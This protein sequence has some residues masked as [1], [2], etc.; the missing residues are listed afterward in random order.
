MDYRLQRIIAKT[1]PLYHIILSIDTMLQFLVNML[2][3][4]L[5]FVGNQFTSAQP[6]S[7]ATNRKEAREWSYIELDW[8]YQ[9]QTG[10]K[11]SE[12]AVNNLLSSLFPQTKEKQRKLLAPG[13]FLTPSL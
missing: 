13:S 7:K 2:Q 9:R 12:R 10:S 11:V 3:F 8:S 5:F 6:S 1:T 4:R